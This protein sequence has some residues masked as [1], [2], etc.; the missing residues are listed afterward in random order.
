M[1]AFGGADMPI[2]LDEC[3]MG[4]IGPLRPPLKLKRRRR[5]REGAIPSAIRQEVLGGGAPAGAAPSRPARSSRGDPSH[6]DV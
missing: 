5:K 1:L 6:E 4:P 3:K 2:T